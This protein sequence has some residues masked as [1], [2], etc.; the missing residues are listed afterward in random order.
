MDTRLWSQQ[1]HQGAKAIYP[2][3]LDGNASTN[4][5]GK[6]QNKSKQHNVVHNSCHVPLG[7]HRG[8]ARTSALSG[9]STLLVALLLQDLV[10][11]VNLWFC[12]RASECRVVGKSLQQ[13]GEICA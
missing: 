9:Q 6:E 7:L 13:L 12:C 1:L 11:R 10:F 2:A 5:S 3:H 8:I 4:N